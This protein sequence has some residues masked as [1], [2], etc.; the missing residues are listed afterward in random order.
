MIQESDKIIIVN[1]P[2]WL[3]DCDCNHYDNGNPERLGYP[4]Y[5]E[6]CMCYVIEKETE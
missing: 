4:P 3:G 5:H 2:C 1:G 6:G